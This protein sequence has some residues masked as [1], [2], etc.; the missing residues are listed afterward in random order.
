LSDYNRYIKIRERDMKKI[1]LYFLIV[2]SN[3]FNAAAGKEKTGVY[4]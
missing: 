4:G 2:G 1:L 3:L